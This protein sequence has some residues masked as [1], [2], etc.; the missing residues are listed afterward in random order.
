MRLLPVRNMDLILAL[1]P[2][3]CYSLGH[4]SK[5]YFPLSL[6]HLPRS[7]GVS[8]DLVRMT[9]PPVK[10]SNPPSGSARV[11]GVPNEMEPTIARPRWLASVFLGE[12]SDLPQLSKRSATADVRRISSSETKHAK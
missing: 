9:L 2:H 4:A 8:L 3:E 12:Q 11:S 1:K 6:Y 10:R 5:L 7:Y